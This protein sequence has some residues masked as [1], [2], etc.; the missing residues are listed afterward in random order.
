M[1]RKIALTL[2]L[3]IL[4]G[5][6]W[7]GVLAALPTVKGVSSEFEVGLLAEKVGGVDTGEGEAVKHFSWEVPGWEAVFTALGVGYFIIAGILISW[8]FAR[9]NN[10][11]RRKQNETSVASHDLFDRGT[12]NTSS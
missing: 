9:R 12:G 8:V 1:F 3:L 10:K 7:T 11:K 5:L 2:T 6:I 4:F